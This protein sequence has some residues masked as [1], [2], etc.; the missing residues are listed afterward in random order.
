VGR[1]HLDS[2]SE[3]LTQLRT[4]VLPFV[5][6][7]LAS[8]ATAS[9]ASGACANEAVR[10]GL[11]AAL[12][13]CRAYELVTPPDTN[14]RRVGAVRTFG[15]PPTK[16]LFPTELASP[17]RDSVLYG[18]YSS[19]LLHPD[20]ATGV[21]D[22]YE[23][24][25]GAG[26]WKTV[27]RVSPPGPEARQ[28]VPGGA[29]ADHRYALST[30]E[31]T[32][33]KLA[34]GGPTSYLTKPDGTLELVGR[35]PL[36]DEP[37]AHAR[38]ISGTG[39]HVIFVTGHS[40]AGQ[41]PWCSEAGSNCEVRKLEPKAPPTGTGAVYA[42]AVSGLAQVV[43][44]LPG[45][46]TPAEGDQTFFQGAS[47]DGTTVA[48]KING[49]LYVRVPDE[50]DG[51]TLKVTDG[52]STYA[53]MSDDGSYLFYLVAGNIHRFDTATEGDD[54]VGVT[55][56]A[57]VSN[58]SGDGSHVYFISE[59]EINGAGSAGEPNLFVWSGSTPQYIAT[60]DPSDLVKTSGDE[61]DFAAL[62]RWTSRAINAS[63][64]ESGPGAEASRTN[65]DGSVYV[66]ESRAQLTSADDDARVEIYRYDDTDKSLQCL[67]CSTTG[68]SPADARLQNLT[69]TGIP[70]VIHNV[71]DDGDRVL[72]ET[73]EALL[74]RDIDGGVNDIYQWTRQESGESVLDL[75]SSGRSTEYPLLEGAGSPSVPSANV[76]LSATPDGRDVVF[77][78]QD[79]L[80]PG[81]PEGGTAA[82]YDARIGGGFPVP[83][84]PSICVE[85]GCR[86]SQGTAPAL[87]APASELSTGRNVRGRKQRPCHKR[88]RGKKPKR[89][90]KRQGSHRRAAHGSAAV[91]Q[92]ESAGRISSPIESSVETSVAT[93][94]DGGVSTLAEPVTA[95]G[96]F[97][98]FGIDSVSASASTTAA[99]AH[100]DFKTM[101]SLNHL[102]NE[103]TNRPEANAR[104]EEIQVTLP[105]GLVG[106]LSSIPRCKT[107]QMVAFGNCPVE[108][109]VGLA[110]VNA[111]LVGEGTF[112]IYSLEPPHPQDE[113]ARFGMFVVAYTIFLD[114]NVRTA[115]DFG[116]TATVHSSPGLTELVGAETIFW[117]NPA[118]HSH[119]AQ[120]FTSLE[121]LQC[122][123]G[124]ACKAPGG[125][126]ESKLDPNS[127]VFMTNPSACQKQSVGF[128]AKSYQLPGK[129]FTAAAPLAATTGCTDLPFDPS[130]TAEP[131]NRTAGAPAGLKTTLHLPQVEDPDGKG[132]ATMKEARVTLPAGMQIAA[133]AAD[134]LQGCSEDQVGLHQEV[135]AAC[136][137]ASK[138]GTARIVSP[139]L[140]QPLQGVL[141]QRTPIPGRQFGLWLVTD[142]LGLHVKLPGDI[143]PDPDTGQ[144]TVVFSD[145]PQV[146]VEE[147][148]LNIWGGPRAPLQNPASC[149]TYATSYTFTPH[150][151][152]PAVAGQSQM[153]I[154]QGCNQ[155]FSPRLHAGVTK[156]IAGKF[157]PLIVDLSQ[158]EEEQ[159]LRGFELKL[160]DGELAK[161]KGVPLCPEEQTAAGDCP[162]ASKIGHLTA[163]AGPG[164]S[165]L[166][167]PQP[168]KA[169][170]A[171]YLAGPYQG[172]PFSILT[173]VPAQ[174]GPFDLG[175]VVVRSGLELDPESAQAVVKADPLPQFFEGVGLTYRRLH[176]VIDRPHFALNPTDCSQMKV[177]AEAHSTLGATSTPT[178]RFQLGGC[179]RLGF[180][181]TISL[182]LKG[183][184]ER[185]NYPS[186]TATVKARR[187]DANI[188]KVSVAL[189]HSEFL[190]QEHIATICTRKRFAADNCPKGSVYGMAKAWTPLLAKPLEG[191]VY[192]RSSDNPLPDLVA[193]LD[194]ELEVNLIGRIDSKNQ[195][196][197]TNFD[198]VPDAP[199]TKFVLR[200]RGGKKSLLVNSTDVCRVSHRALV[201]MRAQNGR[202]LGLRPLLESSGCQKKLPKKKR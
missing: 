30:V 34:L 89:C 47:K 6:F 69:L 143:E 56:D 48:F 82:I 54:Q 119:D 135:N 63:L 130:F 200:M 186:L 41:S 162:E 55:G 52:A 164:P 80:V 51:E 83:P 68:S 110:K 189:P 22:V 29:S 118:D 58:I 90:G 101:I 109:Q 53:G 117:G 132:T 43:S 169:P 163:A 106:H 158:G 120:R 100:P 145:L 154:D 18:A 12:P 137:D 139:A 194:G 149:G 23:A 179:K 201:A 107:G 196:I 123:T 60:I 73:K 17:L 184:T 128:A 155:F 9:S 95:A 64:E 50:G 11:S 129:I 1:K 191:P 180:K 28:A 96:P 8:A 46:A 61:L 175:K 124:T 199:I 92:R 171:V 172:V 32:L 14:G 3:G 99:G 115:G 26:G 94:P 86:P 45:D 20:G 165:P 2:M 87:A 38:W 98:E 21:A 116:V 37:F 178:S 93:E 108:S 121:A 140:A 77:L 104:T 27:R 70:T 105:P 24:V 16:D 74:D 133:G 142:D 111:T 4:L 151:N 138:L 19:P 190:A 161:L 81:A 36:G 10:T 112:P 13:D 91:N 71:T 15:T 156:P 202:R 127:T 75:I 40:P 76:L 72:F 134:G 67:S 157:S 49:T 102:I 147:I 84:A 57:V 182:K 153:T 181:P 173:V 177:A 150:S 31:G 78:S 88:S 183:G 125:K 152:D 97:D 193:A 85:D 192:L 35:G 59:S 159:P 167:I 62:G 25:R 160:P 170:T 148:S 176:V 197:R 114:V 174:A 168:G 185:S 44:L 7:A 198:S 79:A 144:L 42:R 5:L 166:W 103:S 65:P 126:R 131:T 146:P 39:D 33:N 195:G 66:F 122:N 188:G 136:P 113:V 141:Y 187:G